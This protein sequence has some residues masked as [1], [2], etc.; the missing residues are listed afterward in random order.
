M[1][2]TV[3]LTLFFGKSDNLAAAYGIAVSAT[4][5]LTS[6]LLFIAMRDVWGWSLLTSAVVAGVFLCIDACF[7]L[8]N[9]VKVAQGGY[10]PLLLAALVYG[11]MLIWH[12][13][14]TTVAQR[15]GEQII[16][17]DE[18]MRS[19][20]SQNIP[21]VPGTGVFLT[22]TGHDAPPVMI[23]HVKHNRALQ[24]NLLVL[25]AVTESRPWVKNSER[26]LVSEVQPNYWRATARFVFMEKPDIPSVIK[27]ACLLNSLNLDDVV[28]YVGHGTIVPS[29]DARGLAKLQEA[30]YI[31]MER[32]S[33]HVSDFFRL[34][35]DK[36]VLIGRRI[37]I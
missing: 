18:F 23:W 35:N 28:Y 6:G 20:K 2:V 19:I 15:L 13:G 26:L 8:A 1:I 36:V 12:R 30:L 4:M 16:P 22:R 37:A 29:E 21:R 7:L 34:P 3:S 14:S 11:I 17:V 32:N 9:L 27:Q 33:V 10:L 5:M 25:N 24:E 31:V